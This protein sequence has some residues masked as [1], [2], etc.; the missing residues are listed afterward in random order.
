MS[1]KPDTL[2]TVSRTVEMMRYLAEHSEVAI[3]DVSVALGLA[4][5]T[6]HRLLELLSRVGMV[7][8]DKSRRLYRVGP[9][10][11]RLSAQVY[12]RYEVRN[13]AVPYLKK[14][15]GACNETCVLTLY[16][17][18]SSKLFLVEKVDS[19]HM[20]RYQLPMNTRITLMWGAS[21]RSV[22]A[23]L[24]PEKVDEI[25][26]EEGAA[27][28]SGEGRPTRDQLEKELAIIRANGVATSSGQRINEAVGVFSPV[29]RIDNQIVGGI[30]VTVPNNRIDASETKHLCSLIRQTAIELS[31]AL[32]ADAS[33]PLTN[34]NP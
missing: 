24:P 2:G 34:S 1:S 25:H 19:T 29:F 15:V 27:P 18:A 22:L 3:R 30:G 11:F 23:F 4:P 6:C 31:Q 12:S 8:H 10:F 21:G 16:D 17:E 26:A 28:G 20:L 5:S 9:E 32:G 14:V 13:L 33:N 7:E